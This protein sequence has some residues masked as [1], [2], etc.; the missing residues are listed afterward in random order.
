MHIS[1]E[2]KTAA[3]FIFECIL[4]SRD[5]HKENEKRTESISI[6]HKLLNKRENI[7][8]IRRFYIGWR[9]FWGQET[10]TVHHHK[11]KNK[12]NELLTIK[13]GTLDKKTTGIAQCKSKK[14]NLQLPCVVDSVCCT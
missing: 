14:S 12:K 2:I 10:T 11:T 1:I 3:I 13:K 5:R 8:V 9:M 4:N 6:F 7:Y